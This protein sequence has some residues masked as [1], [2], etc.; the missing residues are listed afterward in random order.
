MPDEVSK[1]PPRPWERGEQ[2]GYSALHVVVEVCR[3]EHGRVYS[4]HRLGDELDEQTAMSWP[5]GGLNEAA[6]ALLTEAV[7]REA[8]VE[9]LVRMTHDPELIK[10]L[11]AMPEAE[12]EDELRRSAKALHRQLRRTMAGLSEAAVREAFAV[13][14]E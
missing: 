9:F 4:A 1:P 11:C 7:R 5:G 2:D 3:D 12:R 14:S 10:R 13:V 8:L 6:F